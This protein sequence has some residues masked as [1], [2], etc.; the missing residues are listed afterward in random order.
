MC[1]GAF[2]ATHE[3]L[4]GAGP[5]PRVRGSRT[6]SQAGFLAAGSIPACAGEPSAGVAV[7]GRP[8]VHPRVCG[9]APVVALAKLRAWGPSPRV[10]GSRPSLQ[11]A[12]GVKGSIPACA[13]EPFERGQKRTEH[14]VH[15]RVCGGALPCRRRPMCAT[16]P[17]PR[18]RGSPGQLVERADGAGSIP[19][20]AGEPLFGGDQQHADKVHPRVCGGAAGSGVTTI[21]PSGPSPRVRGS[22]DVTTPN[23]GSGGSIPACAGEPQCGAGAAGHAGVH[24]RVCGGAVLAAYISTVE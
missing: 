13:G 19:A 6:K 24:P 8:R 7:S 15:P 21:A 4:D 16:G 9:G 14:R 5:S 17:S 2:S 18:V 12:M 23:A 20:C 3:H 22:R 11:Y 1:G 10:R